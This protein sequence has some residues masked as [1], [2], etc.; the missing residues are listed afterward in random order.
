MDAKLRK[1]IIGWLSECFSEM[2]LRSLQL[3]TDKQLE[4]AINHHYDGGMIQFIKDG[5]PVEQSRS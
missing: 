1:E 5:K 4:N 3:L 2:S